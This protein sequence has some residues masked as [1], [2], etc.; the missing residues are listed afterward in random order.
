MYL[1]SWPRHYKRV[2]GQA[3]LL[4]YRNYKRKSYIL[5]HSLSEK[6]LK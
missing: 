5:L 2:V 3:E 1:L 4:I 6:V